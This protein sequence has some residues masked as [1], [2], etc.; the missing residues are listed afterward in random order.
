MSL[1]QHKRN[2]EPSTPVLRF[3]N[4]DMDYTGLNSLNNSKKS[5]KRKKNQ[6]TNGSA[7]KPRKLKQRGGWV[8]ENPGASKVKRPMENSGR[9]SPKTP[10]NGSGR[11]LNSQSP[12]KSHRFQYGDT[13]QPRFPTSRFNNSRNNSTSGKYDWW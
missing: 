1:Q 8:S 3:Y 4:E 5:S 11:F 12:K 6:E 13:S 9:V 10:S 7:T 2:R